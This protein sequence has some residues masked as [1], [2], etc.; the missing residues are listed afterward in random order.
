MRLNINDTDHLDSPTESDIRKCIETLG[1]DQFVVLWQE[2]GFFVQSYHNADGTFELEYRQG[3]ADQHY[4]V[5]SNK[6]TVADVVRGF[7]LFLAGSEELVSCC[8]WELLDLDAEVGAV[9]EDLESG[10]GELV[11]Y[12]GVLMPADWPQE[13]EE[14]QELKTYVSM[15]N[16]LNASPIRRRQA[17]RM[18]SARIAVSWWISSMFPVARRSSVHVALICLLSVA[19]RSTLI[20][21]MQTGSSRV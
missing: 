3:S 8:D 20:D 7:C 9:N 6:I 11:E 10:A 1:V 5:E 18:I 12:H 19:V 17:D 15:G 21:L 13:I 14:A 4:K 16:R 2:E